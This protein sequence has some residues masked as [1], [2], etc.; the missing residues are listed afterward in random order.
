MF[1]LKCGVEKG[2]FVRTQRT[3]LDP[4]LFYSFSSL[5][6]MSG[7]A[8]AI[9]KSNPIPPSRTGLGRE[10]YVSAFPILFLSLS[11]S[12]SF[13]PPS[14]TYSPTKSWHTRHIFSNRDGKWV[15]IMEHLIG[16]HQVDHGIHVHTH[17]EVLVVATRKP[18]PIPL[19]V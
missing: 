4:P 17:V 5:I 15:C 10:K 8:M 11:L 6:Q 2:G 13:L 9:R 16:Q 7:I 12:P 19:T 18:V 1:K 3:P 14:P